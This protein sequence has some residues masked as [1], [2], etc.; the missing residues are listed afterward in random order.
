MKK[1]NIKAAGIILLAMVMAAGMNA[2]PRQGRGQGAGPCNA[3]CPGTSRNLHRG[4]GPG[5][6]G[7]PFAAL[8]LTE[9]QQEQLNALRLEHYKEMK[10]L[11]N[12]MEE[13]RLKKRNLMS[14]DNADLKAV[15]KIIDE[16]TALSNK[17]QK[18]AAE[19]RL[20][21]RQVL[22]EEQRMNLD[23]MRE[24]GQGRQGRNGNAHAFRP[25]PGFCGYGPRWNNGDFSGPAQGSEEATSE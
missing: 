9:E 5:T 20:E 11:R 23:Q 22:T 3:A 14:E 2:Q 12:Q 21:T 4:D 8:D 19:N 24:F 15:N 1:M 25:G 10:P 7:R 18:L 16:Q 17:M 13:L 6:A